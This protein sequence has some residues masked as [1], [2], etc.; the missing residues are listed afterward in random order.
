MLKIDPEKDS[1]LKTLYINNM[2]FY[3]E[4]DSIG[5]LRDIGKHFR[6]STMLGRDSVKSRM[7]ASKDEDENAAAEGISFTEFAYQILQANDFYNLYMK[8]GCKI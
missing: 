4:L 6:V 2:R 5:F 1:A 7:V 8:H 3:I